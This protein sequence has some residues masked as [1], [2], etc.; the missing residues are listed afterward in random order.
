MLLTCSLMKKRLVRIFG[1]RLSGNSPV[2]LPGDI[3]LNVVLKSGDTLFGRLQHQDEGK[4]SIQDNRFH[5]HTIE[6]Q[7]ID[8]VIYDQP[9]SY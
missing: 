7:N 9:S 2:I 3:P 1:E 5:P 6:I 8:V 4:I